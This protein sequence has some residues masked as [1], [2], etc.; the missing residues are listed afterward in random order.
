MWRYLKLRLVKI[1][2][3]D[4]IINMDNVKYVE[5][6]KPLN[7]GRCYIYIDGHEIGYAENLAERDRIMDALMIDSG[8][9]V[10]DSNGYVNNN[11]KLWD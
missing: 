7:S 11:R 2:G 8:G 5:F 6:G 4:I 10:I 3:I 9:V 1:E